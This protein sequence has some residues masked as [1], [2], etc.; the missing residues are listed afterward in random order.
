[1]CGICGFNFEDKYLISDMTN[2]IEH[3]GPNSGGYYLDT[4]I[5]LGNRRLSIIDVSERGKQ[6]MMNYEGD[7]IITYNGEL[8]NFKEIKE[9]LIS[10]G[11][12][13]KSDTD[14]EVVL[15]AYQEYGKHCVKKFN[16]IFALAIWD[17]KKK[18]LFL[19]RDHLGVKPLYYYFKEGKFLFASEIK[20]ILIS[21]EIKAQIN[22][23]VFSEIIACAYPISGGSLFADIYELKPGHTLILSDNKISEECY[24]NPAVE[25]IDKPIEYFIKKVRNLLENSVKM[26][27]VSDVPLGVFLSGGIDSSLITAM[28]SKYVDKSLK[29]VTLG[30]D[31]EEDEYKYA[32]IVAEHCNTDHS[33]IHL[34]SIELARALPKIVWHYEFPFTRPAILAYYFLSKKTKNQLTVS[35]LGQGADEIFAGYN[36]YDAYTSFPEKKELETTEN[37]KIHLELKD[38]INMNLSEK[39]NYVS[40]GVFNKDADVFF[41]KELL[42][43]KENFFSDYRS[44]IKDLK[45]DGS[46]LNPTLLYE[47]KTELPYYQL[48]MVD[49]TS[50]ANSH[51]MRVPILDYKL[52]EFA[53]KIPSK[54]KFH[55]KD[56]KIVLQKVAKDYLP[57]S[58][59]K[60]RKLPMVV[61]LSKVFREDLISLADSVLSKPRLKEIGFY[62]EDNIIK[63]IQKI[64]TGKLESDNSLRQLLFFVTLGL[65]K[66]IFF[67]KQYSKR[68]DLSIEKYI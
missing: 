64:K 59:I 63:H 10:K 5:S 22:K 33:E 50:M 14:T 44:K 41:K 30:F 24:W 21:N 57:K 32:R 53:L 40:S 55:G 65:W 35:L 62:K 36:R 25:E 34:D 8:Y 4:R 11:Y 19:A 2:I 60:R 3:R 18:K 38:K 6:P 16:G 23:T 28:A 15:Y 58:I 20:C 48:K 45:N 39:V 68:I 31:I 13:F 51:E 17:N 67:N 7:L 49:K 54:F 42:K 47:I 26:Q 1:M 27:L 46:Q 43:D 56:K 12:K 66:D 29:T 52:V 61:P 37:G 9:D